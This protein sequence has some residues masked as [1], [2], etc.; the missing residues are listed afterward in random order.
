MTLRHHGHLLPSDRESLAD[1]FPGATP[2]VCVFIH[3]LSATE[4]LWSHSAEDH[5][6]EADV[7]FGTRL[8]SDLGFTP[9]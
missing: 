5:Y 6:G 8:E 2:K 7:T 1:A 9:K 4:W 3:G